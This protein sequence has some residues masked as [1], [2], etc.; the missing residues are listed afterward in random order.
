MTFS[1]S[2][3]ATATLANKVTAATAAAFAG[4][5]GE[6]LAFEH[7]GNTYVFAQVGTANA[8]DAGTDQLIELT[9]VV[10]LTALSTT[11]SGATAL[12]IA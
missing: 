2:A 1:G 5:V 9:G 4:G 12:W 7:N 11:A 6:V 8:F 10:G 3:A